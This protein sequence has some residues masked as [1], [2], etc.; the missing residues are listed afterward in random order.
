MERIEICGNMFA[1]LEY[2][3]NSEYYFISKPKFDSSGFCTTEELY[4]IYKN[5]LQ[6]L[7]YIT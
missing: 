5:K 7:G 6:S 3:P 1:I 4:Y 2:Y